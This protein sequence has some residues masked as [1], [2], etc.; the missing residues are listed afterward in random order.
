MDIL[1]L[2]TTFLKV[3][4]KTITDSLHCFR[5]YVAGHRFFYLNVT[6]ARDIPKAL[7]SYPFDAVIFHYTFLAKRFDP[8][9][10]EPFYE[11]AVR[12][13]QALPGYKVIIPQD[14]Y[15]GTGYLHR[16]VQDCKVDHIFTCAAPEDYDTIY[17]PEIVGPGKCSTVFTGYIDKN[18]LHE[19]EEQAKKA[20]PRSIDI[21]YRARKLPY[22]LGSFGQLKIEIADHVRAVLPEYP[23]IVTDIQTTDPLTNAGTLNGDDWIHFLLSCRTMLGCLGGSG[24]LDVDDS[25][26]RRVNAY[27]AQHPDATFSETEAACFPGLD[28][29]IHLY[30]LS[31]RHFEC[32]MTKTCQILM[33]GDYAG[34]FEPG[35]HYIELKKDYANLRDVLEQVR[36]KE[37]CARIA[38]RCFDDVV[39]DGGDDNPNTYAHFA[40]RVVDF[41]AANRLPKRPDPVL[42]KAHREKVTQKAM[43]ALKRAGNVSIY[44]D[45]AK[46]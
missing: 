15:N 6:H 46:V 7:S 41:I 25:I 26:L 24:L 45:F 14:E 1:V 13:L 39:G 29:R 40:N 12:T 30:A 16:L 33:E 5:R 36:D 27:V 37:H 21:G 10:W 43:K 18:T 35:V 42:L 44:Q 31:P 11:K 20:P 23:D 32:A 34:V 38:Q 2:Y 28:N 19:L 8:A 17:P 9:S 22:W 3:D 4:R